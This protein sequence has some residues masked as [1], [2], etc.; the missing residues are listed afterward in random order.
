MT[1]LFLGIIIVSF[2]IRPRTAEA[3]IIP[4]ITVETAADSSSSADDFSTSVSSDITQSPR[5]NRTRQSSELR[6]NRASIRRDSFGMIQSNCSVFATRSQ[7]ASDYYFISIP[8]QRRRRDLTHLNSTARSGQQTTRGLCTAAW[9]HNADDVTALSAT[10]TT[11]ELS[12]IV[13]VNWS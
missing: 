7:H 9:R 3:D 1:V 11:V 10:V 12:C 6:Q 4:E 5:D 8:I 13:G 2:V